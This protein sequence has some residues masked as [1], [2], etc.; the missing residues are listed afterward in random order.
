MTAQ[1]QANRICGVITARQIVARQGDGQNY[2]AS[3]KEP[4]HA[5]TEFDLLERRVGWLHI[6]LS[7]DSDTW[8]PDN[9]AELI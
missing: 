8:I 6:K 3:F 5:G 9:S 1:I 7:D 2:P 4:L